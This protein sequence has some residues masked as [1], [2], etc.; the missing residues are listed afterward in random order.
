VEALKRQFGIDR[1]DV[2]MIVISMNDHICG[3]PMLQ[4]IYGAQCWAPENF[5]DLLRYPDAHKFPCN[6]PEASR[7]DRELPLGRDSRRGVM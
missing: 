6:W 5:S 7:I 2:A 4:R 1:I 3:V